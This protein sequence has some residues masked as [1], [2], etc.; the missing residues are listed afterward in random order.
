MRYTFS[1]EIIDSYF[2]EDFGN[3]R[4]VKHYKVFASSTLA[5]EFYFFNNGGFFRFEERTVQLHRGHG[6]LKKSNDRLIDQ[7]S[8]HTLATCNFGEWSNS[9]GTLQYHNKDFKF[10]K[11]SAAVKTSLFNIKT[12]GHYKMMLSTDL[13]GVSYDFQVKR[14]LFTLKKYNLHPYTGEIDTWGKTDL[15]IVMT[16][17]Y[18]IERML[19]LQDVD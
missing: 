9:L 8:R 12:W 6:I 7:E 1:K 14:T 15:L 19:V 4:D 3:C 11:G 18:L 2:V 13:D 10:R 16:G 17:L 5:G